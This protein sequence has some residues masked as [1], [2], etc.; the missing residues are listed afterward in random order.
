MEALVRN[1]NSNDWITL[2][3][4]GCLL[5]IGLAVFVRLRRSHGGHHS[6]YAAASTAC[7]RTLRTVSTSTALRRSVMRRSARSRA[8]TVEE[9]PGCF[10]GCWVKANRRKIKLFRR[11][12]FL[13]GQRLGLLFLGQDFLV[14]GFQ[15]RQLL[16]HIRDD[17]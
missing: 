6:T 1:W 7:D 9:I 11:L 3:L 10:D 17:G 14:F 13:R 5:L 12:A 4:V 16:L 2:L 8:S 15:S